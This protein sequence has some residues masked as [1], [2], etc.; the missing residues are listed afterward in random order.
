M[1]YVNDDDAAAAVGDDDDDDNIVVVGDARLS[2]GC[3]GARLSICEPML[4]FLLLSSTVPH[5]SATAVAAA[6]AAAAVASRPN[7]RHA[8]T[9]TPTSL[10]LPTPLLSF[11]SLRSARFLPSDQP[12]SRPS[13]PSLPLSL[14][15]TVSLSTF[16]LSL[17][18]PTR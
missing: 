7:P 2:F 9:S 5:P 8:D 11:F 17:R 10:Y 3:T 6:A 13:F 12:P 1:A 15:S 18:L 14:P 4:P 16:R